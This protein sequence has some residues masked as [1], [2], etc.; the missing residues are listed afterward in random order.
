MFQVNFC[1]RREGVLSNGSAAFKSREEANREAGRLMRSKG[2][3]FVEIADE[4][5]AT[6][7]YKEVARQ[8]GKFI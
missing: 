1:H 5:G 7:F 4:N 8:N 3:L 2:C 6:L